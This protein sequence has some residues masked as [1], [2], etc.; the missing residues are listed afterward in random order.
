MRF[1]P[2]CFRDVLIATE[3][4]TDDDAMDWYIHGPMESGSV[5]GLAAYPYNVAVHHINQCK[6][7]GL[8]EVQKPWIDGS[9]VVKDLTPHGHQMLAQ[10]R[11]PSVV[12]LWQK[13]K[14]AGILSS[15]EAIASWALGIA[16]MLQK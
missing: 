12:R 16:G 4:L 3:S 1:D 8:I 15:A 5:S 9:F 2:D 7:Q 10:L 14:E 6:K 13:A 11:M